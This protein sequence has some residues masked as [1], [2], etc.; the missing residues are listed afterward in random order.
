MRKTATTPE[1]WPFLTLAVIQSGQRRETL[2]AF[3]KSS[4]CGSIRRSILLFLSANRL[5]PSRNGRFRSKR[6]FHSTYGVSLERVFSDG[7]R[8][9]EKSISVRETLVAPLFETRRVPS[10]RCSRDDPLERC[11]C[12]CQRLPAGRSKRDGRT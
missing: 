11:L 5:E 12:S 6:I 10:A 2:S 1:C 7:F 4:R 8:F 3:L 9:F